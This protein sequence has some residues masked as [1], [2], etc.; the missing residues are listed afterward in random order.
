MKKKI[1]SMLLTTTMLSSLLCTSA[2][3]ITMYTTDGRTAQVA[4]EYVEAWKAV[5]WYDVPVSTLYA[6]VG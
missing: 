6:T 3:A 5:G 2:S 1:L 4:D